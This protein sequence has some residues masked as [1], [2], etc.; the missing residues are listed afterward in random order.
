MKAGSEATWKILDRNTARLGVPFCFLVHFHAGHNFQQ[1]I[2]V[3]V[4]IVHVGQ[5]GRVGRR[6]INQHKALDSVTRRDTNQHEQVLRCVSAWRG[7]AAVVRNHSLYRH[8]VG[9]GG[10]TAWRDYLAKHPQPTRPGV[11]H[12]RPSSIG[13]FVPRARFLR[14]LRDGP[15]LLAGCHIKHPVGRDGAAVNR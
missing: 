5:K 13:G 7:N 8:E 12:S 15:E 1:F 11:K 3:D 10:S 6:F 4:R 9:R 2:E 14:F